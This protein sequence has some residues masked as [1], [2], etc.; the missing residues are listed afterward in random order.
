VI[1]PGSTVRK[2]GLRPQEQKIKYVPQIYWGEIQE[3]Q[4]KPQEQRPRTKDR[5]E[6][7][8]AQVYAWV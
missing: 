7:T 5:K 3:V 2:T 6:W 1:I 8:F 4:P